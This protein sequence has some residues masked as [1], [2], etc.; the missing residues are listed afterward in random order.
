M[1]RKLEYAAA[2]PFIKILGLLPRPLSRAL[3]IFLFQAVY[4]LHVRLRRVG[5]RNLAMAFPEKSGKDRARILRGEFKSLGRELAELCQL[6]R[7]T[8]ENVEQVV[9][10]DG[11]ENYENAF[12]RKKG[13]L[14]LT[15]HF[16]GWELSAFV[17]SLHGHWLHVVMRP[18]DNPYLDRLIQSY[19]TM[20]GNKAVN[21]DDFI[22][23]LLAAMKAGEV[24]GILMDTNMTPPQGIFVNFFEIPAC[25]ASGI[26]RIALRTDA[27]V[28]PAFTIW[29]EALKKYRLRFDPALDL[30]RTGDQEADIAANTQLFTK[31]IEDYVRKY[32]DQ[33]LWVHRRWK[34]RPEGEPPL[35]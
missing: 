2:W 26:A 25:T 8:L 21:K 16:G 12:A 4:L 29:D 24:V 14:F 32:P 3:S 18:M 33:W 7:Y 6:P 9:V 15:A 34:T 31:V 17:H 11:L 35:Y 5:M 20:H 19:R 30:I 1:R 23:G 27:A 13:V 22:R 10:Y 28:V